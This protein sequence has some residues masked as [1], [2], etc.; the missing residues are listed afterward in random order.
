MSLG[1]DAGLPALSAACPA[2]FV[3]AVIVCAPPTVAPP[4]PVTVN[5]TDA[6]GTLTLENH[7]AELRL[8]R[9]DETDCRHRDYKEEGSKSLPAWRVA[10]RAIVNR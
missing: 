8:L 2:A 6:P 7:D 4:L 3:V 5:V 10:S 1:R 9:C